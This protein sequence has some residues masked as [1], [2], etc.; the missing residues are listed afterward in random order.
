MH[1]Q[2]ACNHELSD[3]LASL[4]SIV[5]VRHSAKLSAQEL[6]LGS[7]S[8]LSKLRGTLLELQKQENC[9]RD[10]AKREWELLQAAI[11]NH[12]ENQVKSEIVSNNYKELHQTSLDY[13]Q[14]CTDLSV[15][16]CKELKDRVLELTSRS[17]QDVIEGLKDHLEVTRADN[18]SKRHLLQV[19]E[20]KLY[21]FIRQHKQVQQASREDTAAFEREAYKLDKDIVFNKQLE[22]KANTELQ[23]LLSELTSKMAAVGHLER[24]LRRLRQEVRNL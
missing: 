14:A 13:F 2:K 16:E 4:Q 10:R 22:S 21:K 7:A 12:R 19:R 11:R 3:K 23:E 15:G 1:D 20:E 9:E 8:H 5:Q 17:M 18:V 24:E 6:A